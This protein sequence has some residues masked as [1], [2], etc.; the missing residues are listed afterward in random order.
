M[1]RQDLLSLVNDIFQMADDYTN[2][3][4]ELIVA[5]H[6]KAELDQYFAINYNIW[7]DN[8]LGKCID[9]GEL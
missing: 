4:G 2:E 8:E 7:R 5:I 1:T 3:K 9:R 6:F